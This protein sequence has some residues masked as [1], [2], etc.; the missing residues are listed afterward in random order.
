LQESNQSSAEPA[1]IY[2]REIILHF[3]SGQ[4]WSLWLASLTDLQGN[5]SPLSIHSA[6]SIAENDGLTP[7]VWHFLQIALLQ[8]DCCNRCRLGPTSLTGFGAFGTC[9]SPD[10]WATGADDL[11][12]GLEDAAE[13]FFN[14][15]WSAY[16]AGHLGLTDTCTRTSSSAALDKR[17]RS[18][19]LQ[20]HGSKPQV[21]LGHTLCHDSHGHLICH[22]SYIYMEDQSACNKHQ[23]MVWTLRS[24][25]SPN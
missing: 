20:Q 1:R 4:K 25:A 21:L 13:A 8:N 16:T 17:W 10:L 24:K 23:Q 3:S 2:I 22:V 18:W 11:D 15:F 9:P 19:Q 12:P 7:M 6:P 14:A 5:C